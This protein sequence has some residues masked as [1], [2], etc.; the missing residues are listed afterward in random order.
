MNTNSTLYKIL[1]WIDTTARSLPIWT[2]L[3]MACVFVEI[4]FILF[5]AAMNAGHL[6]GGLFV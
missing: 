6:F 4:C 5:Y 2:K 3:V 1:D